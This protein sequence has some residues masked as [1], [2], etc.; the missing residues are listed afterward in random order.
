[1]LSVNLELGGHLYLEI[2]IL[3]KESETLGFI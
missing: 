2:K 1:M 3:E